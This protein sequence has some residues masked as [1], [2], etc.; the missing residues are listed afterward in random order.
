MASDVQRWEHR[1]VTNLAGFIRT[2]LAGDPPPDRCAVAEEA[3]RL[4]NELDA[5]AM[6][7]A[8][9]ARKWADGLEAYAGSCSDGSTVIPPRFSVLVTS[10]TGGRPMVGRPCEAGR[11]AYRRAQGEHPRL[12]LPEPGRLRDRRADSR[13]DQEGTSRAAEHGDKSLRE[14]GD[15]MAALGF[16][17]REG[18]R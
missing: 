17:R 15:A 14:L 12:Q 8:N 16:R 11:N 6:K 3:E 10:A 4:A 1:L 2:Y 5:T 13:Q 18:A 7:V 9:D